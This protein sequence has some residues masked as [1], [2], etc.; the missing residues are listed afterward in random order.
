MYTKFSQITYN[1]CFGIKNLAFFAVKQK[2][3]LGYY[4]R[5]QEIIL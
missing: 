3:Q 2:D 5:V 4:L 1:E